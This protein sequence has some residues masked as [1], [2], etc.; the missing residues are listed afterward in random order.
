[1][2]SLGTP[3]CVSFGSLANAS[4]P[5]IQPPPPNIRWC[6]VGAVLAAVIA[7]DAPALRRLVC[8]DS[9]L[10]DAGLAPIVDALPLNHHLRELNV[11]KNNVNMSKAFA[12]ERLLPAVRSNTTLRKLYCSYPGS[13]P[14]E[15]EAQEL[16]RRRAQHD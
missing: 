5:N 10:G 16:V 8:W 13:G 15:A 14:A 1:M 6:V 2:R 9:N 12:R 4:P 11:G 3:A 7:A